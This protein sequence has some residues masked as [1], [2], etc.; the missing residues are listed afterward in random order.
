MMSPSITFSASCNSRLAAVAGTGWREIARLDPSGQYMES[1][2]IDRPACE[3][4]S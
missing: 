3:M 1:I 2:D 4:M